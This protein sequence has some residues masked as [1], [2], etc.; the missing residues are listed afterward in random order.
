MDD[1]LGVRAAAT[2]VEGQALHV[3][4]DEQAL[5]ATCASF[6]HELRVPAWNHDY[7]FG[8]G[9]ERTAN[10]ILLLD[11]LYAQA[12]VLRLAQKIGWDL[13]VSLKQNHREL[14]QSAIRLF[15]HRPPD[16]TFTNQQDGKTYEVQLWDTEGLPFS[17]DYPHPVRVLRSEETLTQN[18]Y[19]QRKLQAETTGQEWLW[20]TTLDMQTFSAKQVRQLGHSRWKQENNGWNDLTQNW[21]FKHG[22][23]HACRHRPQTCS[24]DGQ[25]QP[26][27]N[28]GLPAVTL[29]LLLAFTLCS[30]FALR[31]SKIF[32]RYPMST[33]EVARQLFRSLN[34]LPPKIRAPS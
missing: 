6:E 23:L 15:L 24:P 22:F 12:P 11:A 25:R 32:R 17:G 19:R 34:K 3:R 30:A 27:P 2:R 1:P 28:R 10:Y 16:S 13:V 26:V 5:Q 31:H 4:I 21:A 8:D 29:I 9:T 20:Y 33:I 14:Y 18:H 7:H